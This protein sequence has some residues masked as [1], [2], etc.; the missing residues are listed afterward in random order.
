M[1][2]EATELPEANEISEILLNNYEKM[3][4]N[5]GF[6]L[7]GICYSW[8][9]R[10]NKWNGV[11]PE[12]FRRLSES[13]IEVL[14]PEMFVPRSANSVEHYAL[15]SMRNLGTVARKFSEMARPDLYEVENVVNDSRLLNEAVCRYLEAGDKEKKDFMDFLLSYNSSE[16]SNGKGQYSCLL[17]RLCIRFEDSDD[18]FN[19]VSEIVGERLQKDLVRCHISAVE[20]KRPKVDPALA[21]TYARYVKTNGITKSFLFGRDA[22]SPHSI[23]GKRTVL[24]GNKYAGVIDWE[25]YAARIGKRG[26]INLNPNDVLRQRVENAMISEFFPIYVQDSSQAYRL[27]EERAEKANDAE[28]KAL[29]TVKEMLEQISSFDSNDTIHTTMKITRRRNG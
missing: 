24:A 5:P 18:L 11:I 4:H 14:K 20:N 28:R 6:T 10:K 27:I 3:K 21:D 15:F 12:I 1:S 17:E 25:A 13:K 26:K 19:D 7:W 23:F 2:D 16:S 29:Y 8:E 22:F 9:D